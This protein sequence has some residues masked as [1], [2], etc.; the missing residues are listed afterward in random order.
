M[1]LHIPLSLICTDRGKE[2]PT[3]V[4]SLLTDCIFRALSQS[5]PSSC[6][7]PLARCLVEVMGRVILCALV[8]TCPG[9]FYSDPWCLLRMLVS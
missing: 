1:G 7:L 2:S 8:K 9:I 4:P 6:G 3:I 5:A